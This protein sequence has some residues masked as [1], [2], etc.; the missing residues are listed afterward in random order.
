MKI[1]ERL[2][3]WA[4]GH[5]ATPGHLDGLAKQV[6][7]NAAR[8]RYLSP[9]GNASIW[10]P[11]LSKLGYVFTGAFVAGVVFFLCGH[12]SV[13]QTSDTAAD[14]LA[15]LAKPT[16]DQMNS[17][18]RI[19]AETT[20]LFPKQLRWMA[21]SNGDMGLGVE[22]ESGSPVAD[23]P[24]MLVRMVVVSRSDGES[25]WRPLW[26]T[27]VVLRGEELVEI[28]PNRNSA[29][30]L[31]MWVYPLQNGRVAVDTAVDLDKPLKLA[32]RLNSVVK[33]GEPSEVATVRMGDT[34][35]RLFQTIEPLN[36][37]KG[38]KI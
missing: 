26:A 5:E 23:T 22:D 18:R 36:G 20:R 28:S 6:T 8:N 9:N 35:Y 12:H 14:S 25:A 30:K 10:M 3:N 17:I 7:V 29:N 37:Q 24:P 13:S 38:K 31:T 32:S 2:K 1:E 4:A 27:D 34:E 15:R 33:V 19:F 16:P 21:Q 11:F